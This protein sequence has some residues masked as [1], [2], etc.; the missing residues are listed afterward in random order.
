[1]DDADAAG[2][3]RRA[4]ADPGPCG[5]R[6]GGLTAEAGVKVALEDREPHR[7]AQRGTGNR[8]AMPVG[9]G[10]MD[11]MANHRKHPSNDSL[12][13]PECPRHDPLADRPGFGAALPRSARPEPFARG[14][15]VEG[16]AGKDDIDPGHGVVAAVALPTGTERSPGQ[17]CAES[18][19]H[20]DGRRRPQGA[21]TD[22]PIGGDDDH[23]QRGL[24]RGWSNAPPMSLHR[25]PDR[26]PHRARAVTPF[27][28]VAPVVRRTR[29]VRQGPRKVVVHSD[30]VR[31]SS[32]S[33]ESVATEVARVPAPAGSL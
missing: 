32:S 2:I 4:R 6:P 24:R 10:N 33:P 17:F 9:P 21:V 11:A 26:A 13:G 15:P 7:N 20:P 22:L 23:G 25:P 30:S 29:L 12:S 5:R 3:P 27:A 16:V 1:M 8:A 19:H 28:A 31:P 14:E 18:S